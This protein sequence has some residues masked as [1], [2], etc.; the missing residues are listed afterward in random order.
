MRE[1]SALLLLVAL[2][3]PF[4]DAGV[5]P[6][7]A[8]EACGADAAIHAWLGVGEG[9][10]LG[11][12]LL[13]PFAMAS[14]APAQAPSGGTDGP[15]RGITALPRRN[16]VTPA[17]QPPWPAGPARRDTDCRAALGPALRVFPA[18]PSTAPPRLA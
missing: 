17:A 1:L 10:P 15:R 5:F 9:D 12:D 8:P 2:A 4:R 13:A 14:A 7:A 16:P 18:H 3:V 6:S 11:P